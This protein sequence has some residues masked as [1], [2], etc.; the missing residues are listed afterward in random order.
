MDT[1]SASLRATVTVIL[2]QADKSGKQPC[3]TSANVFGTIKSPSSTPTAVLFDREAEN[4]MEVAEKDPIP[5]SAPQ[6]YLPENAKQIELVFRLSNKRPDHSTPELV[7]NTIF[8]PSFDSNPR[9]LDGKTGQ[10]KVSVN[11]H[12]TSSDVVASE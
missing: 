8:I 10:V 2:T 7:F 6:V 12:D 9:L 3:C 11:W 5:L 1:D 4:S